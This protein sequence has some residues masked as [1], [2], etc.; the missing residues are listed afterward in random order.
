PRGTLFQ[1]LTADFQVRRLG[2]VLGALAVLAY[3]LANLS[4]DWD[5]GRVAMLVVIVPVGVVIFASIWVT[6]ICIAFWSVGA[7]EA[8]NAFTYGGQFLSQFPINVYDQWLRRFLAS[9]FP[10]AFVAYFPALFILGKPDPIGL[11][12]WLR[13]ASPLVAVA[14]AIVARAVWRFGAR[15]YQSAGGGACRRSGSSMSERTSWCGGPPVASAAGPTS[16]TRSRTCRSR[17]SQEASSATSARTAR[18]SPRR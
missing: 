1:L 13:F 15:D 18:A 7:R 5:L 8:S 17:S 9:I 14:A 2:K 4:I 10:I 6:T 16:S 3:A 12:D 11:P